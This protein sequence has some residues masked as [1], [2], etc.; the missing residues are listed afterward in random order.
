MDTRLKFLK[1]FVM[2]DGLPS[3]SK[4]KIV[5]CCSYSSNNGE[6]FNL[7][8]FLAIPSNITTK[9]DNSITSTGREAPVQHIDIQPRS[10]KAD[11]N[12][13]I[14]ALFSKVENCNINI[15]NNYNFTK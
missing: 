5:L 9:I 7:L 3:T 13:I 8:A 11:S 14:S 6:C 15:Y 1:R 2:T 10:N 4:K 12:P